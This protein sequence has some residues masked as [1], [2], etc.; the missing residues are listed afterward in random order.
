MENVWA[1]AAIWVGQ[2]MIAT[3]LAIWLTIST[4]LTEIGVTIAQLVIRAVAGSLSFGAKSDW[5]GVLIGLL[6]TVRAFH[7]QSQEGIYYTLMMLTGLTFGTISALFGLNHGVINDA[8]YS[9]LVATVIAGAVIPTVVANEFL[10]PK[11]LLYL[12]RLEGR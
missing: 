1:L 3:L 8:Q 9:C 10:L 4:A 7:H 6:P 12:K 11:H 5:A 2:A